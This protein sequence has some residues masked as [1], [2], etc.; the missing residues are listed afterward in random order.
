MASRRK[1]PDW[2]EHAA[3]GP[4]QRVDGLGDGVQRAAGQ[5][6]LGDLLGRNAEEEHHEHFVDQEV[7]GYML[8]EDVEVV[9][10]V[11]VVIDVGT[12]SEVP[13]IELHH[14]VIAGEVDIG[15][16]QPGYHAENE[17]DGVF[18]EKG[19]VPVQLVHR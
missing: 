18:L 11:P 9:G 14:I 16:H 15:P 2:A 10:V 5:N 17:R 7:Y 19:Y 12:L 8:A 6:G 13:E 4:H 1:R 3:Q